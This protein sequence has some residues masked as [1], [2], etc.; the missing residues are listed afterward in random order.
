[1][2]ETE[3]A[4][5]SKRVQVTGRRLTEAPPL[6]ARP[7]PPVN[8][9]SRSAALFAF[10]DLPPEAQ[11]AELSARR[12][13]EAGDRLLHDRLADVYA[14]YLGYPDG[15]C[16]QTAD[17]ALEL[18]FMQAKLTL[19]REL[20]DHWLQPAPS[21]DSLDQRG[22]A[23]YLEQLIATN[24]GIF[25]PLFDFIATEAS[26][27]ALETFLLCEVT[28]NEVVDDEVALLVAGLQGT[29]KL[30]AASNL[31]DECGRGKLEHFHTYWLRQLLAGMG[32]GERLAGY[33]RG[34]QP[35]FA[36]ITSNTFNMLLTRAGYSQM[37]YGAFLVFESWVQSH[38]ERILKGLKRVGLD[39]PDVTIYFTAHVSIDPRHTG[40]LIDGVL[41]QEPELGAR[42]VTQ[43][44]RGAHLAV[45][46]GASQYDR[47]RRYLES[48]A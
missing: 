21:P 44:L 14:Y 31:W 26:R 7:W 48:L 47:M 30:N 2:I 46:S 33:R 27:R 10:L 37:A 3:E 35:W 8:A 28:R 1:M 23:A 41:Y 19:E 20:L 22:A 40:E 45:A 15:P 4:L 34:A 43:L 9:W 17:D 42:E 12:H 36:R 5:K 38:F 6:Q 24:P 25:H 13:T 29:Q 39:D 18:K 32:A 16:Y 11:A